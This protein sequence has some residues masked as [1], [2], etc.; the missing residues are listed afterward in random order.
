MSIFKLGRSRRVEGSSIFLSQSEGGSGPNRDLG[1]AR[2]AGACHKNS[3]R[4]RA[5]LPSMVGADEGEAQRS[6]QR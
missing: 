1:P 2:L 4:E 5:S 3:E 6:E